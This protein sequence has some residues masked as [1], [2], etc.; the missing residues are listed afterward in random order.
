M[1]FDPS[2][3]HPGARHLALEAVFFLVFCAFCL[4]VAACLRDYAAS[5][6]GAGQTGGA[7][8]VPAV[9]YLR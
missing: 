7:R 6:G 2:E 4:A 5:P 9:E 1:H 3:R 8:P